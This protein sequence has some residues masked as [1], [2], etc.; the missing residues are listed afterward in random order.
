MLKQ[1]EFQIWIIEWD[2]QVRT[3][4][5][6]EDEKDP[7]LIENRHLPTARAFLIQS[8]NDSI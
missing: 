3:C 1:I 8:L 5:Q 4:F 2:T 6:W 7:E